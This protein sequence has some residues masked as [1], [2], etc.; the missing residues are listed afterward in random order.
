MARWPSTPTAPGIIGFPTST[1]QP[2]AYLD[3]SKKDW[4]PNKYGGNENLEAIEFIKHTF[5]RR[6]WRGFATGR[7]VGER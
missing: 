5:W 2:P 7:T 1:S 4:I 3:Y 6:A